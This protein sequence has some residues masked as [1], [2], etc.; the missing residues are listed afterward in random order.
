MNWDWLTKGGPTWE[1]APREQR[2]E[3]TLLVVALFLL[4]VGFLVWM[5]VR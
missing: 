5:I 1:A 3:A 2:Q 4:S